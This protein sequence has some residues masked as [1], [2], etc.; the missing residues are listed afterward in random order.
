M[1]TTAL[2]L[3]DQKFLDPSMIS[4]AL[5]YWFTTNDHV[6]SPFPERIHKQLAEDATS[7]MLKWSEHLSEAARKEFNDEMLAERFEELLFEIALG[8]VTDEDEKITIKYPFMPRVGDLLTQ[9]DNMESSGADSVIVARRID[10]RGDNVFLV[11]EHKEEG[12]GNVR[13]DEFELPE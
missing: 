8:L 12:T 1:E 3:K 2:K 4:S 5:E 11:V 10:K 6:R 9:R 7:A 13:S